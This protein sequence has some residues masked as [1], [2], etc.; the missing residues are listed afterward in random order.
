MTLVIRLY[1]LLDMM[2][3]T[4]LIKTK[5]DLKLK[6]QGLASD[7]GF[8]LTD[9]VNSSLRQFVLNQGMIISKIPMDKWGDEGKW[10]TVVDF[11]K[12]KKGGVKA[13]EVLS[14]IKRLEKYE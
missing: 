12:F 1:I 3:T 6:A 8:S 11:T 13:E 10:K 5:K 4:I 7:L 9:I 14:S 2:D